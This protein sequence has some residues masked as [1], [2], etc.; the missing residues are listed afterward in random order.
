[1]CHISVRVRHIIMIFGT[2]VLNDDISRKF[3]RFF[4]VFIFR[5]VRRV[6]GQKIA[7]M[8]NTNFICHA[9]YFR[10]SIVYDHGFRYTCV[11]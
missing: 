6:T 10:N 2:L 3:F 5:A 9:P 11:K 7:Q 4:K 8:K 1:M